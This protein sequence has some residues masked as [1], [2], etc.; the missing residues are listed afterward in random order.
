MLNTE[1]IHEIR[2]K[3]QVLDAGIDGL[4]R[5]YTP[6]NAL[7]NHVLNL[8]DFNTKVLILMHCK[9]DLLKQMHTLREPPNSLSSSLS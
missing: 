9:L 6:Q 8:E 1:L 5:E 2:L 4:V 7:P 3:L